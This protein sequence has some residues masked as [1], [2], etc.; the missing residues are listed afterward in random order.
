MNKYLILLLIIGFC[1]ASHLLVN[2]NFEQPLSVGWLSSIGSQSTSDTID[3]QTYFQPD[4]DYEVRVRKYDATHAKLYQTVDIPTTDLDFSVDA[5]LYAYEY[6]TA[7]TYWA[8][9]AVCLRYLGQ[10]GNLLG[11]T[12]IAHR[13]MHCSW[14]SSSYLHIINVST[15]NAWQSFTF[16]VAQELTTNLPLVNQQSIKKID[17]VLLDT[18]NGC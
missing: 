18:T 8:A 7:A 3:Q 17:V 5:N 2:G 10:N 14:T 9:A 11:E 1:S 4:P 16:N 15:G 13:S 6:N 12:R